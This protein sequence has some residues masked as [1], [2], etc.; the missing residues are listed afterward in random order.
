MALIS[1]T[2]FVLPSPSGT[3]TPDP[4]RILGAMAVVV[5]AIAAMHERSRSGSVGYYL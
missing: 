3:S 1:L 4:A 2:G 5:V